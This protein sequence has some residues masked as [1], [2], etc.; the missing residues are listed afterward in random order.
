MCPTV[1]M[2]KSSRAKDSRAR[3]RFPSNGAFLNQQTVFATLPY[4]EAEARKDRSPPGGPPG[5]LGAQAHS[6]DVT[7]G[8]IEP[9]QGPRVTPDSLY[10]PLPRSGAPSALLR[11]PMKASSPTRTAPPASGSSAP[12]LTPR[13]SQNTFAALLAPP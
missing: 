2:Y 11:A 12:S 10:Y 3:G 8:P 6:V 7:V 13:S 5:A 4:T 1:G 9:L